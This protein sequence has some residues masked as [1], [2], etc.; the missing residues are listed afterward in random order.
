[1]S[2]LRVKQESVLTAN[3]GT[4]LPGSTLLLVSLRSTN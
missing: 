2:H 4:G 3:Y 1:L